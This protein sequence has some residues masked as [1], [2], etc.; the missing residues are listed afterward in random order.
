MSSTSRPS[1]PG[2]GDPADTLPS[3]VE[4]DG[5]DDRPSITDVRG[6]IARFEMAYSPAEGERIGFGPPAAQLVPSLAYLAASFALAGFVVYGQNAP[7]GSRIHVWIVE[8]DLSR[9]IT[10]GGIALIVF[11]SAVAT[12]IRTLLRG[13][14]VHADGIEARE[15]LPLGIPRVRKWAWAQIHR[16]V[17]APD[18]VALELW[19]G[20]YVKLP[21]VAKHDDL[22][23]HVIGVAHGRKILIT[24]LG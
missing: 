14:V 6:T 5:S 21:A 15:L 19:D 24:H 12:V 22:T 23:R 8:G 20:A 3:L 2:S 1:D 17:V 11:L 7:S 13:V 18:R 9:P 4:D 10:S 16:V